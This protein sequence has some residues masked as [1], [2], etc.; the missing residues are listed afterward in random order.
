MMFRFIFRIIGLTLAILILILTLAIWKGGEPFRWL[1][2]K[3]EVI[4]R[5]MID[6]GD[7]IDRLRGKGKRVEKAYEDL[8]GVIKDKEDDKGRGAE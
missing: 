6:L 7:T 5:G 3:T 1:G 8:K 2:K 4:A